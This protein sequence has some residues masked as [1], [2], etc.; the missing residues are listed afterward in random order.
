MGIF[1][2]GTQIA[3]MTVLPIRTIASTKNPVIAEFKDHFSRS[4]YRKSPLFP[5]EGPQLIE[6]AIHARLR[7]EAVLFHQEFA[8]SED[9]S[10]II[11]KCAASS[12]LLYR[13]SEQVLRR[14]AATENPQGILALARKPL[15]EDVDA[16]VCAPVPIL[17]LLDVQDPGNC[18]TLVRTFMA[19][20][21]KLIVTIDSTA[22][23]YGPKAVRA[24]AGAVFRAAT[25]HFP[26]TEKFRQ[27][28]P[29]KELPWIGTSPSG[30][31]PPDQCQ[32]KMPFILLIGNER[33]GLPGIILNLCRERLCLP[34]SRD[35]ESLNAA[36]AGS[37]II[38]ELA[39]SFHFGPFHPDSAVK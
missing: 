6:D 38:Y 28:E 14:A 36:V 4:S 34:I 9:G 20:G 13:T 19:F 24:S 18:G 39:R 25:L 10:R 33:A 16:L 11:G 32:A 22:D 8:E 31:R 15:M 37:L 30:G 1:A 26:T 29:L 21:G 7:V 5:I 23:P 2:A 3:S 17:A 35:I 12:V 27:F